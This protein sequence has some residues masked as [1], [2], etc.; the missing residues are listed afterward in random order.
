MIIQVELLVAASDIA[1]ALLVATFAPWIVIHI[2][3]ERP[4][5]DKGKPIGKLCPLS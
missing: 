3:A 2:D 4:A 5:T 1:I